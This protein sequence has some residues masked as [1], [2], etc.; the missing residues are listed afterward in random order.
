M[1]LYLLLNYSP[2]IK[3]ER[4]ERRVG[5]RGKVGEERFNSEIEGL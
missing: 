1:Y 4:E 3:R 5:V 2:T